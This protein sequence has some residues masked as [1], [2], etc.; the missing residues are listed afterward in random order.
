M[1]KAHV[2]ILYGRGRQM[3]PVLI[4]DA[5]TEERLTSYLQ[6][7]GADC[8]CGLDRSWMQGTMIPLLWSAEIQDEV[9]VSLGF[10]PENPR[11]K[12]EISMT[13]AKGQTNRVNG[14]SDTKNPDSVDKI[15]FAYSEDAVTFMEEGEDPPLVLSDG[16]A[17]IEQ[18]SDS[19]YDGDASRATGVEGA[20]VVPA[21]E[22]DA[23]IPIPWAVII[24]ALVVA[25]IVIVSLA[26]MIGAFKRE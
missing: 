25:V 3:G 1:D 20:D 4:E 17:E 11:T 2:V 26:V 6:V 18:L 8:E 7:I 13:V 16:E 22:A 10:D 24:G 9:S 23:E 12:M 15:S 14:G 19:L 21:E 5:I